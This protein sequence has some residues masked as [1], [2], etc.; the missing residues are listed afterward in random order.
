MASVPVRTPP[1]S[2]ARV[3]SAEAEEDEKTDAQGGRH[4]GHPADPPFTRD[5]PPPRNDPRT[6]DLRH[7]IAIVSN[8]G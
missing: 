7:W 5:S 4:R 6:R 3:S 1:V 2:A 8:I